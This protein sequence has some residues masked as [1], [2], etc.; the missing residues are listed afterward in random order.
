MNEA[1]KQHWFQFSLRM[2]F[3]VVAVCA[4]SASFMPFLIA[5]YR[6]WQRERVWSEFGGPGIIAPFENSI[7]CSFGNDETE[8]D[9]EER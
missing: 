4:L 6:E 9:T 3:A 8:A 2:L 1:S 7:S 5:K